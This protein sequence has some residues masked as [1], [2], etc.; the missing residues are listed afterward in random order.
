MP[1]LDAETKHGLVTAV[2]LKRKVRN[3]VDLVRKDENG[4]PHTGCDIF[5]REPAAACAFSNTPA[6]W[7]TPTRTH[8]STGSWS[9]VPQAAPGR[10]AT[11]AHTRFHSMVG[12]SQRVNKPL[13]R[14]G[15]C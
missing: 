5:V 11:S 6:N 9:R 8:F 7:A 2:A 1:R 4:A 14:P 12:R 10:R 13:P 3:F 15:S